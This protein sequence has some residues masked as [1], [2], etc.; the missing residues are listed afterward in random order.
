MFHK[1]L[2]P[3]VVLVILLG[4]GCGWI[5]GYLRGQDNAIPPAELTTIA[6]P[7]PVKK[8]WD[9]RIG[10]GT[11][12]AFVELRP[13]INQ[14]RLYAASRDGTVEAR[15]A[16]TGRALWQVNTKLAI[17]AGTGLGNGLVLVGTDQGQVLALHQEDGQEA[18]RAQVSSE[19]LA[20]PRAAQG[21]VVVRTVD[22]KFTGLDARSGQRLWVYTYTVPV[23]TL[24]GAAAPLLAQGFVI[25]GLDTGKLLVLSLEKG[26][27]LWQKTIAPPHGRTELERMVDIDSEPRVVEGVLYT[28]AYQG[29]ITAIDLRNGNTLW[30]RKFSSPTG[31]DANPEGVYVVDDT[32]A[33]WCLERRSG[34]TLWKQAALTGRALTTPAVSGDYLA[35]GDFEGYVHWLAT[36][37][38]KL[39]G[40]IEAAG[41]GIKAAPVVYEN[42]FYVLGKDGTLSAFQAGG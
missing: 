23:L 25:A 10:S 1:F 8:L 11:Q 16:A 22:G 31:L 21:V 5:T 6:N 15:D 32:D 33:V 28:V 24:R 2:L 19:V 9:A 39:V 14:G 18:W 38:G 36:D 26:V 35:V 37:T 34:G 17:S 29:N 13:A 4:S 40:R 30:S 27:P 12:G 20:T 3:L 42:A 41:K 7:I